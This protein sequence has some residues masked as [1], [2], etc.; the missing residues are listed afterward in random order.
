MVSRCQPIEARKRRD[1]HKIHR[2]DHQGTVRGILEVSVPRGF[3]LRAQGSDIL[4]RGAKLARCIHRVPPQEGR[5]FLYHI[6]HVEAAVSEAVYGLVRTE[7][8]SVAPEAEVVVLV[9]MAHAREVLDHRN[10]CAVENLLVTDARPLQDLGGGVGAG[11]ENHKLSGPNSAHAAAGLV[12][13]GVGLVLDTYRT[14]LVEEHTDDL[15]LHQ[16]VQIGVIATL[17]L[18]V[19]ISV[20]GILAF[21]IRPN[22]TEPALDTIV[23]VQVLEILQLLVTNH[24]CRVDKVVLRFLRPEGTTGDVDRAR[25]SVVLGIS[26]AMIGFELLHRVSPP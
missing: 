7:T 11:R 22:V 19:K 2:D 16:D 12:E 10:S 15:V 17:E 8:C 24:G 21:S 23:V 9:V 4:L 18:G 6:L 20:R 26:T 3:E 14:L 1:P 13:P 5:A 25:M